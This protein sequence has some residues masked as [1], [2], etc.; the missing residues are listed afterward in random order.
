[1]TQ[2]MGLSTRALKPNSLN[3]KPRSRFNV[4]S[5]ELHTTRRLYAHCTAELY[6]TAVMQHSTQLARSGLRPCEVK[7]VFGSRSPISIGSGSKV[8]CGE[9]H[10]VSKKVI[11]CGI[12]FDFTYSQRNSVRPSKLLF[13]TCSISSLMRAL[14]I[15]Y[16]HAKYCIL[17]F[18]ILDMSNLERNSMFISATSEKKCRFGKSPRIWHCLLM[19][20]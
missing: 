6:L 12:N 9:H 20:A 16:K 4:T 2:R 11:F 18:D 13:S 10:W 14:W 17:I 3:S 19:C 7:T 8:P 1:M 15:W 5:R